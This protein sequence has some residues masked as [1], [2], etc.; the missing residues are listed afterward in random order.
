MHIFV[1]YAPYM[2]SR[3]PVT[4]TLTRKQKTV[5][6]SGEFELSELEISRLYCVYPKFSED[7][8]MSNLLCIAD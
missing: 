7:C 2:Y 6:V 8:V 5:R 4:E 3:T 1:V